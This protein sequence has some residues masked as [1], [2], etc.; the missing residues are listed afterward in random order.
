MQ[1]YT[2]YFF[3]MLDH[4]W[5]MEEQVLSCLYMSK[6]LFHAFEYGGYILYIRNMN[7]QCNTKLM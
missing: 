3:L 6:H 7:T 2:T 5:Q 4:F 1:C